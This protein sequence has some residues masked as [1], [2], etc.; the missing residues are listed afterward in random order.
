[1]KQFETYSYLFLTYLTL[2]TADFI[3]ICYINLNRLF[4]GSNDYHIGLTL[5][6]VVITVVILSI[7]EI[8]YSV[9][10][11]VSVNNLS[12]NFNK[13]RYKIYNLKIFSDKFQI[14]RNF[15]ARKHR[16]YELENATFRKY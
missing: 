3:L 16:T 8:S 2:L 11:E 1:M 9:N 12:R 4:K 7:C 15:I 14:D 10:R 6:F 5:S 13:W